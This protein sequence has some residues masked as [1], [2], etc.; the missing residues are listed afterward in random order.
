MSWF[1]LDRSSVGITFHHHLSLLTIKPPQLIGILAGCTVFLL[2]ICT[3]I[4]LLYASGSFS[5][6]L[7]ELR[8]DGKSDNL[9]CVMPIPL[10]SALPLYESQPELYDHLLKA[11]KSLGITPRV[12]V[13][14]SNL[15]KIV[16]FGM[17]QRP[18]L[19]AACNGSALCGESQYDPGIVFGWLVPNFLKE[20]DSGSAQETK[21]S[22]QISSQ[23]QLRLD[24]MRA[25]RCFCDIYEKV[26]PRDGCHLSIID[27][28][29]DIP[30]GMMSLSDNSPE[31]LSVR[32]GTCYLSIYDG[33]IFVLKSSC[34]SQ[35]VNN[36]NVP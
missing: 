21:I 30:I 3:V 32:I 4:Y 36:N 27:A 16:P 28:E 26:V 12:P 33:L 6:L 24:V 9:S 10:S 1:S 31:N 25:D 13:L 19:L 29:L 17:S 8:F 11:R 5:K 35:R 34:S 15:V 22:R 14:E 2:T 7:K 18:G 20:L 23:E